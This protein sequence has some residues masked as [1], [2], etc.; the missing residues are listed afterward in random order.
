M[1]RVLTLL[2]V[3][4]FSS[5]LL[6]LCA[7]LP[8]NCGQSYAALSDTTVMR[9]SIVT[10]GA[11]RRSGRFGVIMDRSLSIVGERI[12][13]KPGTTVARECTT[14]DAANVA[15]SVS[16]RGGIDGRMSSNNDATPSELHRL[17]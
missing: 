6:P 14:A 8:L 7:G 2:R 5:V 16:V 3:M 15:Q 13:S 17:R 10:N 1:V 4:A 11:T 9:P 12:P